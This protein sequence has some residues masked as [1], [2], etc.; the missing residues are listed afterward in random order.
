M[1][2]L[3]LFLVGPTASG[4]S[5]LAV[6]LAQELNGE[7][8]S[9]DS[10]LVYQSMNI[11]TAKPTLKE[12]GR[13]PHHGIDLVSPS[14]SFSVFNYRRYALKTIQDIVSRGKTP[15]VAGG[16]GFYVRALLEGLSPLPGANISLRRKL[17]RQAVKKGLPALCRRLLKL[18]P[19]R[20]HAI[21]PHN[22]RRIVRALE[23][24]LVSGKKPSRAVVKTPGLK[25]LGFQPV[26]IGLNRDREALYQKI[27]QRVDRMFR[28]GLVREVKRLSKKKLSM[29][30]LQ[31]VGY[32]ETLDWLQACHCEERSA[33][34]I[35]K[36]RSP[37][38]PKGAPRDN[39]EL[40]KVKDRIKQATRH[41]AKRQWTWFKREQGIRWIWWPENVS[42]SS[43]RDFILRIIK[44][45]AG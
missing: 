32:K 21:G 12:R 35:S 25:A 40:G 5:A 1:K 17:E 2:P 8:I 15:I 18:D 28:K 33:E 22:K 36:M 45:A 16:T 20:A 42:V 14:K 44:N 19:E 3:V 29:T 9:A 39:A 11:G 6:S 13:I 26:V 30:A 38:R 31:G 34:A 43:V 37:H 4:K 7:I 27:N 24:Y 41:F 23:I 10:M